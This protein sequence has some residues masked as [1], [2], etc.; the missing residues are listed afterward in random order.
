MSLLRCRKISNYKSVYHKFGNMQLNPTA[1]VCPMRHHKYWSHGASHPT[2]QQSRLHLRV[3]HN[4]NLNFLRPVTQ[5]GLRIVRICLS[6]L[7]S[8]P[9]THKLL[10]L[11][12]ILN[13]IQ[14]IKVN[15][16]VINTTKAMA[17]ERE[18]P[19]PLPNQAYPNPMQATH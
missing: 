1:Y 18:Y 19:T 4:L 6:P 11:T 8:N 9:V 3:V 17:L 5:E 13:S 12:L 2:H 10:L 15:I 16:C 14:G 7:M